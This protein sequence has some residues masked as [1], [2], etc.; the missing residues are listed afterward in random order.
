MKTRKPFQFS[1]AML[2]VLTGIVAVTTWALASKPTTVT[3]AMLAMLLPAFPSL[4]ITGCMATK[5]YGR[6]FWIG[7]GSGP[8]LAVIWIGFMFLPMMGSSGPDFYGFNF[9]RPL[10]GIFW[11]SMI[12]I[13]LL[14]V[15]F[16]WL[17]TVP[18]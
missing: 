14:C 6:V 9:F 11:C 4:A 1:I 13:G 3:G 15:A 12:P 17:L 5:G 8:L 7:F 16:R 10:L 18:E 2:L